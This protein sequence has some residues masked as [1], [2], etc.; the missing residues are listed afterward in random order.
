MKMF[1]FKNVIS[2]GNKYIFRCQKSF[3]GKCIIVPWQ[4][5]YFPMPKKVF[6]ANVNIPIT[7]VNFKNFSLKTVL[8]RIVPPLA[9]E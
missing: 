7:I 3:Q 8:L 1:H 5:V 6:K 2:Y 4:K 9:P